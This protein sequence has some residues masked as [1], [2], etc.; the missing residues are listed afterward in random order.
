MFTEGLTPHAML[1]RG[2]PKQEA[3]E[4]LI[5]LLAQWETETCTGWVWRAVQWGAVGGG[6]GPQFNLGGQHS[7]VAEGSN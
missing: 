5:V 4:K 1:A 3:S 2:M 6:W 7:H